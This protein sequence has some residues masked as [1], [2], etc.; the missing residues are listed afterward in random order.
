M[1]A[2]LGS[3]EQYRVLIFDFDGTLVDSNQPKFDAFFTVSQE[4]GIDSTIT[5]QVL[6]IYREASRYEIARRI[7]EEAGDTGVTD[8]AVSDFAGRY[9][10]LVLEAVKHCAE[11]PEA[12]ATL[13][14][15]NRRFPLY[16]SSTTPEEPLR[17]IVQ[18]RG[19]RHFFEE[20]FGYPRRKSDTLAL[21]CE[22]QNIDPS[23]ALVIG[24]GQS[25]R[26]A[27]KHCGSGFFLIESNDALARLASWMT[28]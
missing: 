22:Q 2:D 24:D 18:Y 21:I 7:L 8:L 14:A 4:F 27:A 20:I 19:W 26:D 23:A 16:L 12:S 9:G 1:N 10:E 15:M 6:S 11:L 28:E 25:D 3:P 13:S 17:E 5:D